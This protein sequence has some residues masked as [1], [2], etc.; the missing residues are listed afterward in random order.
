MSIKKSSP[1]YVEARYSTDCSWH[2]RE[3][4]QLIT[5]L[6]RFH[7]PHSI[8]S[9]GS[10]DLTLEKITQK[11]KYGTQYTLYRDTYSWGSVRGLRDILCTLESLGVLP[12]SSQKALKIVQGDAS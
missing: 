12:C 9:R 1:Y 7:V 3:A 6:T 4:D 5:I 2:K 10:Q 11:D 8:T